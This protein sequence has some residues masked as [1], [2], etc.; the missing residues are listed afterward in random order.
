MTNE[1]VSTVHS[2]ALQRDFTSTKPITREML[3][4][5]QT[6]PLYFPYSYPRGLRAPFNTS[7]L[8]MHVRGGDN[9]PLEDR[10]QDA[11]LSDGPT[12]YTGGL[13]IRLDL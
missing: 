7:V 12:D 13:A 6:N 11:L 8:A 2:S 5:F 4:S 10:Q 3:P 1:Q 9:H